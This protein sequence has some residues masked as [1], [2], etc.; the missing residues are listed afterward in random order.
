MN[1]PLILLI[2]AGLAGTYLGFKHK[3]PSMKLGSCFFD[4]LA[5]PLYTF[6]NEYYSNSILNID[7]IADDHIICN[8]PHKEIYAT[9]IQSTSS[10]EKFLD[11]ETIDMLFRQYKK[12]NTAYFYYVLHKNHQYQRQ[13]I[14]T[15]NR[16]IVKNIADFYG[17]PLLSGEEIA[18]ALLTLYTQNSYKIYNKQIIE[19]IK[20]NFNKYGQEPEFMAFKKI[21]R[22][23]TF[24]AFSNL[25]LY[26]AYQ[27]LEVNTSK[28]TQLFTLPFTGSIWMYFNFNQDR[29]KN[30]IARL[31]SIAKLIGKKEYF[32]QLQKDYETNEQDL[33]LIN[34][35]ML[36]KEYQEE[37][38]GNLST[39]LKIRTISKDLAQKDIIQKTP[40]KF[41]DTEFDYLV[42]AD[43]LYNFIASI[44]KQPAKHPDITGIDKS[45][46]FINY[47]FSEEND[48][49]HFC[50]IA[51]PGSGK[52]VS[53]QKII[54]QMI[55][56]DFNSGYAKELGKSV[57]VRDYDIGFSDEKLVN[58]IKN[59]KDN[60]VAH[61]ENTIYDF[62]YNIASIDFDQSPE[63]IDADIEFNIDLASITLQSLNSEPLNIAESAK[64]KQIIYQTYLNNTF[65]N[66]RINDILKTHPKSYEKLIK[67]NYTNNTYL[68][69]IKEKE[70]SFLQK[71]ILQDIIS[72]ARI[73]SKNQQISQDERNS[74]AKL[75]IKLSDIEQIGLFNTFDKIDIKN[76]D[77]ISMDLN[78][79][80]DSPYFVPIYL[81][82]FQKT[83]LKDREYAIHCR[84]NNKPSPKLLYLLEEA[85]NF[86]RVPYF[87]IMLEKIT[88]E[89]RKYNVHLGFIV[90]NI[91]HIPVG[92][93]RNIDT[94]MFLL[95]PDKK[96]ETVAEIKE[97]A[98]EVNDNIIK[99][100]N[101]TEKYE[102]CVIYSNGVFHIK[103]PISDNELAIFNT[104]PNIIKET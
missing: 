18:N 34:G 65:G 23:A 6:L 3:D 4:K 38:V 7:K 25:D 104:N 14:F 35:I 32:I 70:Y 67:L 12:I 45:G 68:K 22:E 44:H 62:Q 37:I 69:E 86:F 88:L 26:Q 87:E 21:A 89:A 97:S 50:I 54:T 53:K 36:L 51:K 39:Y 101:Q 99:A 11:K 102:I 1:I 74:Y 96:E 24:K 9:S 10:I 83:Y 95:R 29:I 73:Q 93:I 98:I 66:Y 79:F 16:N 77:F 75:A 48:N 71:P 52:S 5:T 103:L 47:S 42:K 15:P 31:I 57:K 61:I 2:F 41:R 100:I 28:L 84:R 85:K 92:I 76:A 46:S 63:E 81:S 58:L 91:N 60:N 56:L 43:Y 33:L 55:D 64:M 78:N 13:Y 20:I 82:I 49:P 94:R 19:N 17:Q 8:I 59:N 27:E 90:Q 40:I 30:H 72:S 80:K